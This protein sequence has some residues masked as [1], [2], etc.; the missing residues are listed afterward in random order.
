MKKETEG[1]YAKLKKD[2]AEMESVLVAFSGGVDSTLLLRV[3][4]DVL[5]GR[6]AAATAMSETYFQAEVDEAKRLAREFDVPHFLLKTSELENPV[7]AA[8]PPDRCYYCKAEL[9]TELKTLA[10]EK[11]LRYV[12]DGS[13]HDDAVN[14]FRPGMRA[15]RELGVRSPLRDAGLT[16]EEIREISFELGLETWDK[17][18]LA[19]L[20][21]RFPYGI[22]ITSPKLAQVAE[23]ESFLHQLGIRNLRVRHHGE[24]ARIE[25]NSDDFGTILANREAITARFRELGFSYVT[26]D[27]QGYRT[28]SMNEVLD[29]S[30]KQG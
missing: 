29:E 13:N 14:D 20:S 21:S 3:A 11:G 16:K 15:A 9:F 19:C 4:A 24:T 25:V 12:V 18:A 28:G 7:F 10:A 6:V 2:L 27:L 8:N 17:P 1:K 30:I 22:T 5:P 26:L 23:A